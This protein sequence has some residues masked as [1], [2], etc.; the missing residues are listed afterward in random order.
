MEKIL[1]PFC[2]SKLKLI[3]AKDFK[4]ELH[5]D[6]LLIFHNFTVEYESEN[7]GLPK[8]V[9]SYGEKMVLKKCVGGVDLFIGKE[10]HLPILKLTF[11]GLDDYDFFVEDYQ[12]AKEGYNKIKNWLLNEK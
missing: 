4:L 3:E 9:N 2:D 5:E 10:S 11:T 1:I 8:E 6:H 12:L 7:S